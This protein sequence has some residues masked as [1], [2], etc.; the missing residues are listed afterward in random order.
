MN[1][2]LEQ[3]VDPAAW[4]LLLAGDLLQ[5]VEGFGSSP[6]RNTSS[7]WPTHF[8]TCGLLTHAHERIARSRAVV[9]SGSCPADGGKPWTLRTVVS[10]IPSSFARSF[11][12]LRYSGTPPQSAS[13]TAYAPSFADATHTACIITSNDMRSPALIWT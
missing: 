11:A 4:A 6:G 13:A 12:A 3:D 8:M 5:Q 2:R 7:F 1:V 9:S 10:R